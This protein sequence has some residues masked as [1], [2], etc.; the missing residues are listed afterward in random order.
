MGEVVYFC[1]FCQIRNPIYFI[2]LETF[3]DHRKPLWASC[4]SDAVFFSTTTVLTANAAH[5]A[6]DKGEELDPTKP[7]KMLEGL[8]VFQ[9]AAQ[10]FQRS[11]WGFQ[12]FP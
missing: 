6:S 3:L 1:L 2:N 5:A 12:K 11:G 10:V 4:S 7:V 8:G 9:G